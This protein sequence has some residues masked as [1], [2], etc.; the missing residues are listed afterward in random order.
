MVDLQN[1]FFCMLL[2]MSLTRSS[3]RGIFL[4]ILADYLLRLQI[5]PTAS[6]FATLDTFWCLSVALGWPILVVIIDF[7][8]FR[9][10]TPF[11]CFFIVCLSRFLEIMGAWS[12]RLVLFRLTG[13]LFNLFILS[14]VTLAE[15]ANKSPEGVP[16]FWIFSIRLQATQLVWT[17]AKWCPILTRSPTADHL[18]TIITT[19]CLFFYTGTCSVLVGWTT[20]FC[21]A[22]FLSFPA[23]RSSLTTLF[24]P[25]C[26]LDRHF[27]CIFACLLGFLGNFFGCRGHF[28]FSFGRILIGLLRLGS[29]DTTFG[30]WLINFR[31]LAS[32]TP[33]TLFDIN[34][35]DLG[36]GGKGLCLLA[37]HG[38]QL[39]SFDR[40]SHGWISG[41]SLWLWATCSLSR[42][43]TNRLVRAWVYL[44]GLSYLLSCLLGACLLLF[45]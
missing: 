21:R 41:G 7:W 20:L 22:C 8:I 30:F 18:L 13:I 23:Y 14:F 16:L 38:G 33:L 36:L 40:L 34:V 32:G 15:K 28:C 19:E 37:W 31:R 24:A 11:Y 4:V 26:F 10:F 39:A 27:A 35:I 12:S 6:T 45:L 1:P 29:S 17:W 43:R 44:N 42:S 9:S 5:V 2:R 3:C 25:L